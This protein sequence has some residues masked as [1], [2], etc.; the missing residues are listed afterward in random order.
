MRRDEFDAD[1][2][3]PES[4]HELEITFEFEVY[5]IESDDGDWLEARPI[6]VRNSLNDYQDVTFDAEYLD[7][8]GATWRIDIKRWLLEQADIKV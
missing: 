4:T 5:E 7:M 3:E 1:E 2:H 8:F 6:V